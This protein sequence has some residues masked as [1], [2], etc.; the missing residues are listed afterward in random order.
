MKSRMEHIVELITN[1][2][3]NAMSPIACFSCFL[4]FSFLIDGW[5][6]IVKSCM[7][8]IVKLISNAMFVIVY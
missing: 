3:S 4:Q 8:H 1:D 2:D 6:K 5:R 7:Q